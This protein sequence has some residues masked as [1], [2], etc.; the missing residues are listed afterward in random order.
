MPKT[1]GANPA[2]AEEAFTLKQVADVE[3]SL[4]P[5]GIQKPAFNAIWKN[6]DNFHF[7]IIIP[8]KMAKSVVAIAMILTKEMQ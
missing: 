8:W 2:T 6:G 7:P 5:G 4:T 3:T 1:L